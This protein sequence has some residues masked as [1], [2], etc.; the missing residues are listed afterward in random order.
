VIQPLWRHDRTFNQAAQLQASFLILIRI[1]RVNDWMPDLELEIF[2]K[3]RDQAHD[4]NILDCL[5]LAHLYCR[6][7]VTLRLPYKASRVCS[8]LCSTMGCVS[9]KD[10]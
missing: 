7:L 10:F 4:V 3:V 5:I 9:N 6:R 8:E 2:T 1:P